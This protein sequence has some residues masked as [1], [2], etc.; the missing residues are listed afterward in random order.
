MKTSPLDADPLTLWTERITHAC[1]NIT[2]PKTSF[3][4]GNYN[5]NKNAFQKDAYHLLQCLP[6]GGVCLGGVHPLDPE[7]DPPD[8]E[9]DTPTDP[10]AHTPVDRI[11][12][13]LL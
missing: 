11:L 7:A 8:P 10:E 4:G 6:G 1:E 3:A 13:T 5:S 9:A 12:D 2:L